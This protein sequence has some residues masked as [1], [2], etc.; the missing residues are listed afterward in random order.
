MDLS[1]AWKAI[2][3]GQ[4][5]LS[6]LK[7]KVHGIGKAWYGILMGNRHCGPRSYGVLPSSKNRSLSS[8]LGEA[9]FNILFLFCFLAQII[10]Y[11]LPSSEW[12]AAS[13]AH[14]MPQILGLPDS[15]KILCREKSVGFPDAAKREDNLPQFFLCTAAKVTGAREYPAPL[16]DCI[17][18]A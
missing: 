11:F 7:G 6:I 14:S 16:P 10:L 2:S 15:K 3:S 5:F 4:L 17:H 9:S 1:C 12:S 18:T 8:L 13:Q